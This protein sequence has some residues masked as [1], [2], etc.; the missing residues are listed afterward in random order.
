MTTPST[1]RRWRALEVLL[2]LAALA[3]LGWLCW[4]L[5]S[6]PSEPHLMTWTGP[7]GGALFA[8]ATPQLVHCRSDERLRWVARGRHG[9]SLCL[10]GVH[11]KARTSSYLSGLLVRYS[12]DQRSARARW[13]FPPRHAVWH[14]V[15]LLPG[16]PG[17]LALVYRANSAEG[18]L[19][20]AIAGPKGWRL[21]PT[22]LATH[23]PQATTGTPRGRLLGIGW[24]HNDALRL[25]WAPGHVDDPH[26]LRTPLHVFQS[27]RTPTATTPTARTPPTAKPPTA[28]PPTTKPTATKPQAGTLQA[29]TPQAG[30]PQAG[31]PQ[32]RL[33]LLVRLPLSRL[34]GASA[35]Q[36][37]AAYKDRGRWR[38]LARQRTPRRL[39]IAAWTPGPA[40]PTWRPAPKAWQTYTFMPR[41][42]LDL[43]LAGLLPV[44]PV[45]LARPR[46]RPQGP[47]DAAALPREAAT[48]GW[49]VCDPPGQALAAPPLDLPASPGHS[50]R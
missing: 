17:T 13:P 25:F 50:H 16:P 20:V 21:P 12:L 24:H 30:T 9:W 43:T 35:C 29:R 48:T 18:P 31:T 26:G 2:W 47:A 40:P 6:R 4:L 36:L 3:Q 37:V 45:A 46:R 44:R 27:T 23:G 33:Q 32:E 7:Q 8:R 49:P 28:K 10:G 39:Q 42:R 14:A 5:M 15:G 1:A 41:R 22:P 19:V 34:C 38:L 11:A